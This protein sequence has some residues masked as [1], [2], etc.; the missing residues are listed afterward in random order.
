MKLE[1]LVNEVF[2]Y[3]NSTFYMSKLSAG[4]FDNYK[5]KKIEGKSVMIQGFLV[6]FLKRKF[7][8]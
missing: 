8:F 7:L 6:Q 3:G 5:F 1:C 2:Y 4:C